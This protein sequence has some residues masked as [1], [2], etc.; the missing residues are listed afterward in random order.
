MATCNRIFWEVESQ[1]HVIENAVVKHLKA[2]TRKRDDSAFVHAQKQMH[3]R[4]Q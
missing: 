1:N 2:T 3:E 4:K